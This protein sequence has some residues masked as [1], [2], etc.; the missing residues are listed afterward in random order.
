LARPLVRLDQRI[1]QLFLVTPVDPEGLGGAGLRLAMLPDH[2]AIG[3]EAAQVG[4][5]AGA[6]AKRQVEVIAVLHRLDL[7]P[8]AA[9]LAAAA[10]GPLLAALNDIGQPEHRA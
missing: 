1:G 8:A 4:D 9:A 5:G 10:L 7:G 6:E 2:V 3:P